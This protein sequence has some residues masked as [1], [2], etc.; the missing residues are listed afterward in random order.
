MLLNY[1]IASDPQETSHLSVT[2]F[3]CIRGP[4][5]YFSNFFGTTY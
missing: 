5:T 3:Q 2:H 1:Y 4:L